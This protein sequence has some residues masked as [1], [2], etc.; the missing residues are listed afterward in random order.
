MTTDHLK[1]MELMIIKNAVFT[2]IFSVGIMGTLFANPSV[3]YEEPSRK[4]ETVAHRGA[5]GYAPEN[6]MA[7]FQKSVDMKAD[8]IE[9]DVQETKDGKLVVMHDVTLDRTTNGSGYVKDHTLE[10]IR[11]LD[12]GSSFSKKYAGEIV[13]T[14]E[15]VLDRFRGKTGILVE[16]KA[17]YYYPDIEQKVAKA[18]ID[19]QMDHPNNDKI[20]IQSFEPDAIKKM[21]ELLP[22]VPVAL[23]TGNQEDLTNEKLNEISKYAEYVNPYQG[24]I[25][26]PAVKKIHDHD[27][28][29]MGWTVRHKEEVQPLLDANIDAIITNYPDYVP[30][31]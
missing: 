10:E 17:T 29:V 23:L 14:F 27:M 24:L 22:K 2:S 18:L 30:S 12:A 31:H 20:I 5:S 9:L 3:A 15:E 6:T 8:Y 11:R 1:G 28:G 26:P 25:N 21:D 13:P 16:L 7:S 19:R 4:I